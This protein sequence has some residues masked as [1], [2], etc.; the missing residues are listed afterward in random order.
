M[1]LNRHLEIYIED[2]SPSFLPLVSFASEREKEMQRL[3]P[4]AEG[5]AFLLT[6][7]PNSL[8]PF[9]FIISI[10]SAL[11][12]PFLFCKSSLHEFWWSF[13]FRLRFFPFS[14]CFPF[15]F[16]FWESSL[17]GLSLFLLFFFFAVFTGGFSDIGMPTSFSRYFY[18]RSNLSGFKAWG[19][20]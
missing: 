14:F 17:S 16:L 15:G 8:P 3:Q 9:S 18:E 1:D 19:S 2:R 20:N 11:L 4:V 5:F 10:P 7:I 13:A 6:E 12:F